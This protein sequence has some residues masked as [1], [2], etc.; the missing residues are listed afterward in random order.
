MKAAVVLAVGRLNAWWANQS[1]PNTHARTPLSCF[2]PGGA[3]VVTWASG[4]LFEL[5]KYAMWKLDKLP[6]LPSEWTFSC[7]VR[8]ERLTG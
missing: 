5:Q 1:A 6:M 3:T 4:H 8:G 2:W 7:K